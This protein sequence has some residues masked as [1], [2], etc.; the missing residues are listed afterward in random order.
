MF[1][2]TSGIGLPKSTKH[3]SVKRHPAIGEPNPREI[4]KRRRTAAPGVSRNRQGV[5]SA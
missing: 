1:S 3:V 4:L 5:T 2:K